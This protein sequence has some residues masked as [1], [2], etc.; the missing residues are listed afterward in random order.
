[1]KRKLGTIYHHLPIPGSPE[2][3][4][5]AGGTRDN[6]LSTGVCG[7][8]GQPIA[9]LLGENNRE[10]TIKVHPYLLVLFFR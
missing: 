9:Y 1:M 3:D 6:H 10:F 4:F 8:D 2:E 7:A 5:S